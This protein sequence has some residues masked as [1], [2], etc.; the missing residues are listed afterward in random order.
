[1]IIVKLSTSELHLQDHEDG[2]RIY[3]P[4]DEE[5]QGLCFLDRIP[6]ALLE[7][8]MT[9]PSTGICEDFD[10]KAIDV[11][12]KILQATT[13]QVSSILERAGIVSIKTPDDSIVNQ[14]DAASHINTQSVEDD[15][16][17]NHSKSDSDWERNTLVQD[18]QST[19]EQEDL[20]EG[21]NVVDITYTSAG[22]AHRSS[23]VTNPIYVTTSRR[24]ARGPRM[25]LT[26]ET[27]QPDEDMDLEYLNILRSIVNHA[28]R[29]VFPSRGTFDMGALTRSLETFMPEPYSDYFGL[30][31]SERIERDKKIGAAGELFVSGYSST[32]RE[33]HKKSI[34]TSGS[35]CSR[36]YHA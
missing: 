11:M 22:A 10:D 20:S 36:S 35:R 34:L 13:K 24:E 15:V 26:P 28:R 32:C 18:P 14:T 1:M 2:L 19:V 5:Q 17:S 16:T 6:K 27:S 7:W 8:I 4:R 33:T 25:S 23:A 30:R 12:Q 29:T 31:S 9:E 3:V 21:S